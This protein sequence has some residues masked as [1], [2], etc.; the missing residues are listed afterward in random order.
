MVS[1]ASFKD[2]AP[3]DLAR[4]PGSCR[5]GGGPDAGHA[6]ARRLLPQGRPVVITGDALVTINLNYG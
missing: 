4:T 5:L 3:R 6:R 1:R 2:V